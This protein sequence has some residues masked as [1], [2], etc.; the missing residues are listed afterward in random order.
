MA[1]R[2]WF[3]ELLV[4]RRATD[5]PGWSTVYRGREHTIVKLARRDAEAHGGGTKR[6]WHFTDH[7]DDTPGATNLG[8]GLGPV[9]P[10]ARVLAEAWLVAP[11]QDRWPG[12]HAPS[13][14]STLGG[15]G[16]GFVT[17][18]GRTMTAFPVPWEKYIE[19]RDHTGTTVGKVAPL[20]RPWFTGDGSDGTVD[21]EWNGAVDV[22]W[23]GKVDGTPPT[24]LQ[25]QPTYHEI[26]RVFGEALARRDGR[27]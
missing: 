17:T 22:E 10:F 13:L 1:E 26:L 8:P 11:E 27:A 3:G 14:I 16:S 23:I 2:P 21:V 12:A 4:W 9:L 6:G 5:V 18:D 15:G 24:L 7:P 25:A 19:I 20:L